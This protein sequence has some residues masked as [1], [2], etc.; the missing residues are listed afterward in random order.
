MSEDLITRLRYPYVEV[1]PPD[2]ALGF[3]EATRLMH[4]AAD[5]LERLRADV[6]TL[7]AALDAMQNDRDQI[8]ASCDDEI[9]RLRKALKRDSSSPQS[10]NRTEVK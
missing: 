5:E 3:I 10:E 1:D 6:K 9:Q 4:E 8:E 2:K 7:Q